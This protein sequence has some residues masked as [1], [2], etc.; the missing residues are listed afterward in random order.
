MM[1]NRTREVQLRLKDKCRGRF[2]YPGTEEEIYQACW[3]CNGC[4]Q[5]DPVEYAYY[6]PEKGGYIS[7]A[8]YN[9]TRSCIIVFSI[10][11]T[12]YSDER[13]HHSYGCENDQWYV[14]SFKDNK[15][16]KTRNEDEAY[17]FFSDK[18]ADECMEYILSHEHPWTIANWEFKGNTIICECVHYPNEYW[19]Q[20]KCLQP[21]L[22]NK[23][24]DDW[25]K[26][27]N[28]L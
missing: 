10:D 24:V 1:D 3:K 28:E 9:N 13:E 23:S 27:H 15:L 4:R 6:V 2:G 17:Q 19:S 16:I 14:K 5:K 22:M 26:E 21:S 25:M 8:K 18:A 12:F 11:H 7:E 20:N